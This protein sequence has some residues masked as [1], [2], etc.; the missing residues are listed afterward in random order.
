MALLV[1][2]HGYV[3]AAAC[4]RLASLPSADGSIMTALI[5]DPPPAP[6]QPRYLSEWNTITALYTPL[7]AARFFSR[8]TPS[9]QLGGRD[10]LK[11]RFQR[12][13]RKVLIHHEF[14]GGKAFVPPER[15]VEETGERRRTMKETSREANG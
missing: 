11:D 9:T 5:Y 15:G 14:D 12:E 1:L 7:S 13:Q 8:R 10:G 4:V 2:T 6:P 3:C